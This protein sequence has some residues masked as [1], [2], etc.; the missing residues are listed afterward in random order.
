MERKFSFF[1]LDLF[2]GEIWGMELGNK[3]FDIILEAEKRGLKILQIMIPSNMS[4]VMNEKT[5]KVVQG[6]IREF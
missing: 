3:I 5:K 1:E 4:F 6:Y 2:S